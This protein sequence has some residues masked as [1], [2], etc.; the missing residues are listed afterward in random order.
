MEVCDFRKLHFQA[1][2]CDVLPKTNS[3]TIVDT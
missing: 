1:S 3:S 2:L